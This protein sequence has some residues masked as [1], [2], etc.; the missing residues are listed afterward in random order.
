M[1]GKDHILLGVGE[2]RNVFNNEAR[3]EGGTGDLYLPR[4]E[5]PLRKPRTVAWKG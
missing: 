4:L 2:G 1:V 5:V 3:R